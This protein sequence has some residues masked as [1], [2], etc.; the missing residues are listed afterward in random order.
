MRNEQ[1][2]VAKSVPMDAF[3]CSRSQLLSDETIIGANMTFHRKLG[4]V[5]PA[6]P[7]RTPATN[8]GFLLGLSSSDGHRRR[9]FSEYTSETFDFGANS[10]Y[11]RRFSDDYRAELSGSFNFTLVEIDN[12]ALERIADAS[13]F[14]QVSDLKCVAGH[15]DPVL[16]GLLG[17]L[18]AR[19]GAIGER[20]ALF[21]DQISTAI[22][23]HLV[24]TYGNGR[25]ASSDR[26]RNLSSRDQTRVR[27]QIRDRLSG[28]ISV[29]GLARDCNL[30]QAVFLRALK[31]STGKTPQQL[32]T[33]ERLDKAQDM[34][35]HSDM[36]LKE[37]ATA[38]GFADQ[39]HFTRV[40]SRSV[41]ATPAAWRRIRKI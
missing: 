14:Q 2:S 8:R 30:S 25:N 23:I 31:D 26:R 35:L 15:G 40:F 7:V 34:M 28:E 19:V 27:D 11:L 1:S 36:L 12:A 17:A 13:D 41:G 20:S 9:I 10:V 24:Q 5:A 37:V 3:G 6:E 39:S 21:V 38:C 4:A 32:L 33:Q 16:G 18:F 22:G 29:E